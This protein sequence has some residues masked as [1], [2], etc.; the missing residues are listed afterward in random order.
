MNRQQLL[1]GPC[2]FQMTRHGLQGAVGPSNFSSA[3][4]QRMTSA[5]IGSRWNRSF[6]RRKRTYGRCWCWFR[7]LNRLPTSTS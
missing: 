3:T 4:R 5:Y 7:P 2:N 6:K 1:L